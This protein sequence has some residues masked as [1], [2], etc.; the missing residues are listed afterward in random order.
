ME[1]S[2]RTYVDGG[3]GVITEQTNKQKTEAVDKVATTDSSRN[4]CTHHY[5]RSCPCQE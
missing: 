2:G 4:R 3:E 5:Y 1:V